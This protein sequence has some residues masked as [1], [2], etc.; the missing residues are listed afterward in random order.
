MTIGI[1]L[2]GTGFMG[3]CHALAF[4]A[5]PRVFGDVA[6][7]RLAVLCDTPAER[8]E[9]MAAQFGFARACAD[10]RELVADPAVDVI[11]IARG[12][13]D[14]QTLLGFSDE[15]LLRAVAAASTPIVSAIGHE[16]DHPLLDDVAD[17]EECIDAAG[18]VDRCGADGTTSVA[19][20]AGSPC[21]C[22]GVATGMPS[23]SGSWS[24]SGAAP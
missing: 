9:A 20:S 16:N 18:D 8:A 11:V 17:A 23:G 10:W 19:G 6:A 7:P 21:P 2:V 22:G 12:G 1:G 24:R 14:P 15:R 3:K 5:A 13:G 4:A